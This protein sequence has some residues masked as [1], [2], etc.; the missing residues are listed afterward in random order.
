MP[1]I[2]DALGED[3]CPY[4]L[5]TFNLSGAG[6]RSLEDDAHGPGA[7]MFSLTLDASRGL[8]WARWRRDSA[9]ACGRRAAGRRTDRC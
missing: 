7:A 1:L 3:A 9:S 5:A 6:P 2:G 8:I 4:Y